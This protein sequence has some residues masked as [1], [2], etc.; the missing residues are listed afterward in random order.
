MERKK[1]IYK[2]EI[3]DNGLSPI[4]TISLVKS[5]AIEVDF[6]AL[7]KQEVKLAEID[8]EKRTVTGPLLIPD[9][10]IPRVD[11]ST[12]EE[13]DILFTAPTIETLSRLYL[14]EAKLSSVNI[15][16]RSQVK[17]V[18]CVESWLKTSE[19]DKSVALGFNQ[20]IGTWFTTFKVDNDDV[21]DDI[22]LKKSIHGFSIEAQLLHS[23][24]K[25]SIDKETEIIN[26]IKSLLN[27]YTGESIQ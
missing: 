22:K 25:L 13:Y 11:E 3:D 8:N 23:E 27:D 17:D 20:P 16:H 26:E 1:K 21:W 9:K 18:Y 12:G 15:E 10:L 5:P 7:N 14:K 2:M 4:S 24:V 19:L 6:V